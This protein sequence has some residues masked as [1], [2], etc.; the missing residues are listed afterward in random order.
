MY[1]ITESTII[2]TPKQTQYRRYAMQC[3]HQE[4]MISATDLEIY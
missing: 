1:N 2:N 4:A 3:N